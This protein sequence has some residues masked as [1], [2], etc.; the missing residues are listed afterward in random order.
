MPPNAVLPS[1]SIDAYQ[2]GMTFGR[3]VNFVTTVVGALLIVMGCIFII[4]QWSLYSR[5]RHTLDTFQTFRATLVAMEKISAERGP[6]NGAL[7]AELPIPPAQVAALDAARAS[8]DVA[9]AQLLTQLHQRHCRA[10]AV[11]FATAVQIQT[12][13]A[14][15]RAD[16]DRLLDLPRPQRTAV[17]LDRTIGAMADIIPQFDP[18]AHVSGTEIIDNNPRVSVSLQTAQLAAD[19]REQAGLLGSR[20]TGALGARRPLTEAEQWRIE[21]TRGRVSQLRALIATQAGSLPPAQQAMLGQLEKQ[22]VGAGLDYVAE[23]REAATRGSADA[24]SPH[25]FAVH[26]VPLMYPIIE[27]RDAS[28]A[29]AH[30]ELE[31]RRNTL[32]T[33]LAGL[34][35]AVFAGLALLFFAAEQ[36]RQQVIRPLTEATRAIMRIGSGDFSELA[37]HGAYRGE[38]HALFGAVQTLRKNNLDRRQSINYASLIQ[39]AILPDRHLNAVLG[40]RFAALWKPRDTVGGDFY[41][42]RETE[43]GFVIG[44]V[45]CAGHGVPGA[46]MTMLAHATFDQAIDPTRPDPAAILQKADLIARSMLGQDRF[47]A[48]LASTMDAGIVHFSRRTNTLTFSGARIALFA[49][50]GNEVRKYNGGRRALADARQGRFENVE[51]PLGAGW[52]FYL[53]TDGFLDQSGGAEGFGFGT[54]RLTRMLQ[55][56]APLPLA[57]QIRA[58][59]ATLDAWRG[60]LAQRDD[61]TLLAF[62]P[63]KEHA[64]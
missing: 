59:D 3:R 17:M 15:A 45:D 55:D 33:Q 28:L 62:R 48:T 7:G 51:V 2:A 60:H 22:Y 10:C 19:L 13:L 24:P 35:C 25:E 29:L 34:V 40:E 37:P 8:S 64:S 47:D 14:H 39:R 50:N 46:L 23:V 49:S 36:I 38:M 6:T 41:L 54:G 56:H 58:F 43:E 57:D 30:D 53:S 63:G 4:G 52:T 26:Y 32:L 16:V 18:L 1:H 12:Q 61:V 44:V 27:L 11:Q 42:S 9:L 5:A 31:A 21:G 20:F